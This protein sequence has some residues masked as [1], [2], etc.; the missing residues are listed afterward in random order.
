MSQVGVLLADRNELLTSGVR[1]TLGLERGVRVHAA[2]DAGVALRM[3]REHLPEMVVV[4]QHLPGMNALAFCQ[5]LKSQPG[6][7]EC[8]VVLAVDPGA[9][10]IKLQGTTYGIDDY[11]TRPFEP[12]EVIAKLRH[13]LRTRQLIDQRK[14][15][16]ALVETLQ[17]QLQDALAD[18]H[19]LLVRIIDMRRPGGTERGARMTQLCMRI[20]ERFG[21]PDV[22]ARELQRA[23]PLVELGHVL[24]PGGGG[25]L[26][27]DSGW[28][29]G[30]LTVSLLEKLPGFEATAELIGALYE[31]WDGTGHPHRHQQGQIPLRSR[32]LRVVLDFYREIER[33]P[34]TTPTDA[35]MAL[36]S[37]VGTTYDPM[38]LVHLKAVV[39]GVSTDDLRGRLQ[40]IPVPELKPG[41]I[42]G[43]D[44]VTDSGMKLLASGARLD[45]ETLDM[46]QRRHML[47]PIDSGAAVLR[48]SI[49]A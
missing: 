48:S 35:L 42:L 13:V 9:S 14:A 44:L 11:L 7:E 45:R 22:H 41:M 27:R 26:T 30:R 8:H 43:E 24:A 38:T 18:R 19:E 25:D 21:V 36:E 10:A 23:A 20:A 4:G 37:R 32:I 33:A 28:Q 2:S 5:M 46:I 47:E 17:R 40:V 16:E 15:A 12:G 34:S 39:T 1:A 29:C 49:A 6:L 3:A 31:N